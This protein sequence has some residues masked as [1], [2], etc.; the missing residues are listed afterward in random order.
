MQMNPVDTKAD[1]KSNPVTAIKHLLSLLIWLNLSWCITTHQAFD[2]QAHKNISPTWFSS[3]LYTVGTKRL[4]LSFFTKDEH[5]DQHKTI[6]TGDK[7]P[8]F[9]L[10]ELVRQ[11]IL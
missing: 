9:T 7:I 2:K 6:L 5:K 11:K 1:H 4:F 3:K 8:K 10:T